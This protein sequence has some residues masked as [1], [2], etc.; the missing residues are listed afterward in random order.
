MNEKLHEYEEFENLPAIAKG[1]VLSILKKS[2]IEFRYKVDE[3]SIRMEPYVIGVN[4]HG[5]LYISGFCLN[6]N[7][8]DD[9]KKARKFYLRDIDENSFVITDD[10]FFEMKLS[11]KKLYKPKK[12]VIL[13]MVYFKELIDYVLRKNSKKKKENV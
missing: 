1:I 13:H 2:A 8:D 3:I 6:L 7:N 10:T 11:P 5:N 9:K 12:H 4:K